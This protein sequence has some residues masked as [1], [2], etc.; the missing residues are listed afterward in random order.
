MGNPYQ[1]ELIKPDPRAFEADINSVN[2]TGA[3]GTQI[4]AAVT[5][6]EHCIVAYHFAAAN[7]GNYWLQD[8]AGT[9]I[10]GKI[11]VPED[12]HVSFQTSPLTPIVVATGKDIRIKTDAGAGQVGGVMTGYTK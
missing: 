9:M 7:A 4:V 3:T 6:K 2:A 12:G 8:D 5:G 10:T 11:P 1:N